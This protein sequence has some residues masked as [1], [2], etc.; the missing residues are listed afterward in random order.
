[1]K[2]NFKSLLLLLLVIAVVITAVSLFNEVRADKTD[3][4]YGDLIQLFEEDSVI[5]CVIDGKS[6]VT[7]KSYEVVTDKEG[8]LQ[9]DDDGSFVYKKDSDGKLIE[10]EYEFGLN[11]MFLVEQIHE[12]ASAKD[13]SR[14]PKGE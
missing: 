14:K 3:F 6:V 13:N 2:V 7:I 5:S 11:Y 9:R 1:M 12:L 8:K 4:T 10:K